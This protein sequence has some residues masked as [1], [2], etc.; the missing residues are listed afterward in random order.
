VLVPFWF[1]QQPAAEHRRIDENS[2]MTVESIMERDRRE[3]FS[4]S[5]D[6]LPVRIDTIKISFSDVETDE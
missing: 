5:C 3:A 2:H 1:T 4:S 6:I